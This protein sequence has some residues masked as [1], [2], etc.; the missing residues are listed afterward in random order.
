MPDYMLCPTCAEYG[1]FGWSSGRFMNHRCQP[2]WEW[3]VPMAYAEDEWSTVRAASA[4]LAA[5]RAAEKYDQEDYYLM[6]TNGEV[7][8][9]VRD[10]RDGGVTR[11]R[12]TGEAVPSYSAVRIDD[13]PALGDDA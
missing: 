12:C 9:V 11:W 5:Q 13:A 6:R 8:I 4:E 7:T 1:W 10:P 2:V 3:R